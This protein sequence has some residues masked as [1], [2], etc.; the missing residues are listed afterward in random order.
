MEILLPKIDIRKLYDS[1]EAPVTDF[2]CGL[3]CAPHNPS[4]KPFCCDICQ[5]VPAV[6]NQEWDY[7]RPSTNLWHTWRGDECVENP[8]DPAGLLSETPENML[9]LAC[10]GPAD[11]QRPYRALSCRQFPF[12]PY[13][14]S[15]YRFIG[16]A[17]EWEFE[18]TC[19]VISH[20]EA[21]QPRYRQEF[22]AAYD[23]LFSNW[24]EELESYQLHSEDLRAYFLAQQRSIPLLHRDSGT[25]LLDPTNEHL[26]RT[27]PERLS[28]FGPY[29]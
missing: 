22:I 20:L 1:F 27:L 6:Y 19:W 5:A 17:Y 8:E 28:R 15:D 16:M 18:Q 23:W 7:L 21:V 13:V 29:R 4:G 25:Y 26:R 14:S 11:C 9:L 2:D 3:N 12:F 24:V 10:L